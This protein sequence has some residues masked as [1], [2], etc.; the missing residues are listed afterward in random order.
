MVYVI[1]VV[2]VMPV[3]QH[4]LQRVQAPDS[5]HAIVAEGQC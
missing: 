3:L 2:V 5:S 1:R 4:S